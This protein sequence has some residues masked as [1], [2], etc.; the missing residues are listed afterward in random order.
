MHTFPISVESRFSVTNFRKSILFISAGF[1]LGSGAAFAGEPVDN[2][3]VTQSSP[4]DDDFLDDILGED[5][6]PARKESTI[7]DERRA[8]EEEAEEEARE[9]EATP[10]E[11]GKKRVIKTLQKKTFLK[12]GRHEGAIGAGFVTNDPFINRYMLN[13]SYTYHVTE[14]FGVEFMGAYAFDFGQK[15]WK[16]ITKQIVTENQVTPDISKIGAMGAMSFTFSP[17]Y[18]KVAVMGRNIVNFDIYAS[19]GSGVVATNDD[20]EALQKPDVP[21]AV[22]TQKQL[23]PTLNYGG[24]IRMIF[25]PS[26][27]LR[28]DARGQSFI[29]VLESTT[30]EMK[31]NMTVAVS[32][33]FFIPGMK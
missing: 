16:A 30:L 22:N 26:F 15:D 19:F 11:P 27:A 21:I 23:H 31:N 20:L 1:L 14:I 29:E 7:A 32:A 18:G 6:A 5:T 2:D 25:N 28:V 33:A 4:D 8:M 10:A 12:I 3:G 13:S 9:A 17:I 24:G